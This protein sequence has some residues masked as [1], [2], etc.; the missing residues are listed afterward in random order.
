MDDYIG[1]DC[2][3]DKSP[4]LGSGR[5][6]P[7]LQSLAQRLY[8]LR[9]EA[10]PLNVLKLVLHS[11]LLLGNPAL[12]CTD[13]PDLLVE[14]FL[15]HRSTGGQPECPGLGLLLFASLPIKRLQFPNQ[16]RFAFRRDPTPPLHLFLKSFR[17]IEEVHNHAKDGRLHGFR[18]KTMRLA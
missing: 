17:A 14:Y 11:L 4:V 1:S 10:V 7:C 3:Q 15:A 16:A 18:S 2:L 5:R 9:V 12:F 13:Q 8:T 6:Q